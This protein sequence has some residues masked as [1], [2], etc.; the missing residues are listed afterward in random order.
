MRGGRRARFQFPVPH[1]TSRRL[2]QQASH[3]T[4]H[5]PT[6]QPFRVRARDDGFVLV[7]LVSSLMREFGGWDT[8]AVGVG[9]WV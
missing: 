8:A 1:M 7:R 2:G 5:K 6:R 4:W 9:E 3:A